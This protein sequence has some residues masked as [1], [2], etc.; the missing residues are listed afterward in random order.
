VRFPM[1]LKV[2]P[3]K[4]EP[5]QP[6]VAIED[7]RVVSPPTHP[8]SSSTQFFPPTRPR[9]PLSFPPP[10]SPGPARSQNYSDYSSSSEEDY[11]DDEDDSDDDSNEEEE[12]KR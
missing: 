6:Q 11:S 5:L 9:A 8:P 7:V 2:L 1:S 3:K 10:V 4:E 12:E